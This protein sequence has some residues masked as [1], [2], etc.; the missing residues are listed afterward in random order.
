MRTGDLLEDVGVIGKIL[1]DYVPDELRRPLLLAVQ[2]ILTRAPN[3]SVGIHALLSLCDGIE[4]AGG[5]ED[6]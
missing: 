1:V 5:F 2:R 3:R 4:P 6:N